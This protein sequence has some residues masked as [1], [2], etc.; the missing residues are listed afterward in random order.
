MTAHAR[1]LH[2]AEPVRCAR[3]ALRRDVI[4][5]LSAGPKRIPPKYFYDERG[6]ASCSSRSRALPEYYPTRTELEIL[7]DTRRAIAG[8][9]SRPARR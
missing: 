6:L 1:V 3:A 9:H 8:H 2:R 4:A 5:G 7:R